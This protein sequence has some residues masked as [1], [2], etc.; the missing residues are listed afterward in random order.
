[1]HYALDTLLT[2]PVPLW[3]FLGVVL[4]A[5]ALLAKLVQVTYQD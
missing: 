3:E 1:M 2:Y 5:L 4:I